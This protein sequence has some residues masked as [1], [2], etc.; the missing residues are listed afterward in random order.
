MKT[1]LVTGANRGIGLEFVK[2]YN[3][4][5]WRIFACCR[6]LE[7]A[8]TLKKL[9]A[10]NKNIEICHLDVTNEKDI[11]NL[12]NQL[13]NTPI[14]ILLNNAGLWGPRN[15]DFN[16]R[17]DE[18]EWLKVFQTNVVAPLKIAESFVE[19]VA[20]SE[21]KIIAGISSQM[22]SIEKNHY[23][24]EYIYRSS[25]AALNCVLKN[26]SLDLRQ[27]EISVL[28]LEPGW[29]KTDMGGTNAPLTTEESVKGM[30]KVLSSINLSNSGQFIAYDGK[31]IAW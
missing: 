7:N 17:I 21:L 10:L 27:R 6:T 30:R 14:D 28:A 23:G 1:I 24:G 12:A 5:G 11:K 29:V 18:T 20:A 2:Q 13:A 16:H 8:D 15:T 4:E 19:H 3:Q 25:K 31:V 9:C 22:G 26:L